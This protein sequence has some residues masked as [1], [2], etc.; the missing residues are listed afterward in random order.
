MVDLPPLLTSRV[1]S[2]SRRAS[3]AAPVG[4]TSARALIRDLSASME[5]PPFAVGPRDVHITLIKPDGTEETEARSFSE[6][7]DPSDEGLAMGSGDTPSREEVNAKLEAVEARLDGKLASIE[8]KID[9]MFGQLKIV[10]DTSERAEKAAY[11]AQRSAANTKW[12]IVIIALA[13]VAVLLAAWALWSQGMELI[14][15]LVAAGAG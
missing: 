12:N 3:W 2:S 11:A 5:A 7:H 6:E 10:A 4:T 14:A 1:P 8:S 9:L 13:V 15:G